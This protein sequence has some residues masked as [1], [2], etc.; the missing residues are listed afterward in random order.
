MKFFKE[1]L[2]KPCRQRGKGGLGGGWE[3]GAGRSS[4][5]IFGATPRLEGLD[6]SG[7]E[8]VHTSTTH[9]GEFP[10]PPPLALPPAPAY[11]YSWPSIKPVLTEHILPSPAPIANVWRK[12]AA[13]GVK[14]FPCLSA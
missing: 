10:V 11:F 4:E 14:I 5:K 3:G 12:I 6:F 1:V 7:R 2:G 8:Y 13:S 9:P